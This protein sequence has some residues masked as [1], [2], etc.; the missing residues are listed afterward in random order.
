MAGLLSN[1]I[2]RV[3]GTQHTQ[4]NNIHIHSTVFVFLFMASLLSNVVP[5]VLATHNYNSDEKLTAAVKAVS[6]K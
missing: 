1:V 3:L 4:H 5:R 6:K 2:P